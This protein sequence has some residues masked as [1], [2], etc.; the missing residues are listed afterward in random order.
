L[1]RRVL[2]DAEAKRGN[3]NA[4]VQGEEGTS[5]RHLMLSI[6]GLRIP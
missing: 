1:L 2:K 3:L 4:V 5:T 6:N